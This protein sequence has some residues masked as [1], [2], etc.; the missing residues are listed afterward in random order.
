MLVPR[1]APGASLLRRACGD[2][3]LEWGS[4]P[5]AAFVSSGR[6]WVLPPSGPVR[7]LSGMLVIIA[8]GLK[9][10]AGSLPRQWKLPLRSLSSSVARAFS[11]HWG[12]P[13]HDWLK[14]A[15]SYSR[16]GFLHH[17]AVFRFTLEFSARRASDSDTTAENETWGFY[18]T[19]AWIILIGFR[20]YYTITIIG[21]PQNS[22]GRY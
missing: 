11:V 12:P 18:N 3:P 14:P 17:D 15:S 22:I 5:R 13:R 8:P 6:A 10:F 20:G 2:R 9:E 19:E 7:F 4:V 1:V 16:P 21:N